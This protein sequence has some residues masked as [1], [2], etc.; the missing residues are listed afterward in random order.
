MDIAF[1]DNPDERAVQ[2]LFWSRAHNGKQPMKFVGRA[3]N[4]LDN[5]QTYSLQQLMS[6]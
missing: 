4:I 2:C 6:M 3:V 5:K 1:D